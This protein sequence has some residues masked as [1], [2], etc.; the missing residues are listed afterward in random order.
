[1]SRKPVKKHLNREQRAEVARRY[2]LWW[3]NTP[4]RIAAD[5]RISQNTVAKI[6]RD[7]G[8]RPTLLPGVRH[9]QELR[10]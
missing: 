4:K 7:M 10:P 8:V 6:A 1:M 9:E 2:S 5:M 3:A